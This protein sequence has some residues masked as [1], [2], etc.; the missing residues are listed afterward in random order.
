M[1]QAVGKVPGSLIDWAAGV[2][3]IPCAVVRAQ[4]ND[5]SGGQ[6]VT[7][8]KGAQGYAQF[9]P[10]TW[11]QTGCSGS[12]HNVNDSM[13]CYAKLMYQLVQQYHG[14]V[15]DALA[16]YNA[17]PGNLAAGYGYAD[18]ILAA[19]GQSSGLTSA[20]GN[21][22]AVLT[23]AQAQSASAGDDCA[24]S[25]GGQHIGIL[26]G[27]G[28]SLP[29][30]CILR[31][32]EIRALVGALILVGGALITLPGLVIVMAYGFRATGAAA[33]LTQSAAAVPGYGKAVKAATRSR[34]SQ[35]ASKGR[36]GGGQPSTRPAR[37]R[38]ATRSG[39]GGARPPKPPVT[40]P[41]VEPEERV[42]PPGRFNYRRRNA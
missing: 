1:C 8:P 40:D 17:G 30:A 18:N 34:G 38:P 31:K 27:H 41:A 3:G 6:D 20:G 11:A 37:P 7:S 12:P 5:E 14:N 22:N 32:T 16:A 33:A 42:E 28:P 4:I 15:R 23:S 24:F 21:P 25:I 19:A 9:E 26:F 39:G 36:G 13:K 10:G 35:S 29:S 2:I